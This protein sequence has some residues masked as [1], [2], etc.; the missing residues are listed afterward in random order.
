MR[1]K[2]LLISLLLIPTLVFSQSPLRKAEGSY[3]SNSRGS[4]VISPSKYIA[5]E[6]EEEEEPEDTAM[7]NVL[8]NN[9][10]EDFALVDSGIH[11]DTFAAH[12]DDW[13]YMAGQ[14]DD[15]AR[16]AG[17]VMKDGSKVL[18]SYYDSTMCCNCGDDETWNVGTGV[19]LY[20]RPDTSRTYWVFFHECKPSIWESDEGI[21]RFIVWNQT[22]GDF[23]PGTLYLIWQYNTTDEIETSYQLCGYSV[24]YPSNECKWSSNDSIDDGDCQH[25]GIRFVHSSAPGVADGRID[26]YID[27][28][29]T[30]HTIKNRT[31]A[32]TGDQPYFDV[33]N[34]STF[35]GGST[36]ENY[37]SDRN[38][39]ADTDNYVVAVPKPGIENMPYG[40]QD[41]PE[42][43]D[44]TSI[45]P[46]ECNWGEH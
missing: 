36:L 38:Q 13:W 31:F 34:I 40:S 24:E 35:M 9:D 11:A 1:I 42:G 18:R 41:P 27:G 7:W 43:H 2:T 6:E 5:S 21:K 37:N 4:V 44:I 46:D 16:Q 10:F 33:I 25:V 15:S 32:D 28:V 23:Q 26:L 14:C 8:W 17:I 22:N 30:G 29:Y 12:F 39:W 20:M 45:L 19:D 3:Y